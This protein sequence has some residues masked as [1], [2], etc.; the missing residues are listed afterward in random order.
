MD[1]DFDCNLSVE[2]AAKRVLD[3]FV[4][5]FAFLSLDTDLGASCLI[6]IYQV[7]VHWVFQN[8]LDCCSP[9]SP[10]NR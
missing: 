7:S 5:L 1:Y 2:Y 10:C 9:R 6:R 4:L 3:Q 8:T